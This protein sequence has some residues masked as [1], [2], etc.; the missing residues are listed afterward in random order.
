[1]APVSHITGTQAGS[2]WPYAHG[3]HLLVVPGWAGEGG[4]G[5]GLG[6]RNQGMRQ[7]F[8]FFFFPF[9]LQYTFFPFSYSFPC[10]VVQLSLPAFWDRV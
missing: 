5:P 1:M 10:P 6:A 8:G 3:D 7:A 9:S 2:R 4:L